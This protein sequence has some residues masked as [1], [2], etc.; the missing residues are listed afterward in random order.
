M[1]GRIW[2]WQWRNCWP[3]PITHKSHAG[4]SFRLRWRC[5]SW[6]RMTRSPGP[7]T[8]TTAAANLS[9]QSHGSG[10]WN[11][12]PGG[13]ACILRCG[14]QERE[15]SGS[16]QETIGSPEGL[17]TAAK[18]VCAGIAFP[19]DPAR[20]LWKEHER[21]GACKISGMSPPRITPFRRAIAL[22]PARKRGYVPVG[23]NENCETSYVSA[24]HGAVSADFRGGLVGWP[25]RLAEAGQDRYQSDDCTTGQTC[26]SCRSPPR[27]TA[28]WKWKPTRHAMQRFCRDKRPEV[29]ISKGVADKI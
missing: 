4:S 25:R 6:S 26:L 28:V 18:I 9:F 13:W 15:L 23:N 22:H 14:N 19:P 16:D 17:R 5:S 2:K 7:F 12:G 24:K 20:S 27:C 21:V 1:P 8:S 11:P 3:L 29:E 10:I